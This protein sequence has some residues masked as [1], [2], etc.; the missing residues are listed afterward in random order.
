MREFLGSDYMQDRYRSGEVNQVLAE[1]TKAEKDNN[2]GDSGWK[3]FRRMFV[4]FG[5]MPISAM[6]WLSHA[7]CGT[8]LYYST[9]KK[10]AELYPEDEAKRL[11][12]MDTCSV[13][14]MTQQSAM[15]HNL[16]ETQRSGESLMKMFTQFRTANRQYMSYEIN[17]LGEFVSNP[18]W[19]RFKRAGKTVVLNHLVLPALFN[20]IGLFM[21]ALLGDDIDDDDWEYFWKSTALKCFL[22]V[23]TGWYISAFFGE[24]IKIAFLNQYGKSS[25]TMMSSTAFFRIVDTCVFAIRDL[26]KNG[27]D[28][29]DLWEHLDKL[30][31]ASFAPYRLVRKAYKN[32]TD[33]KEGSIW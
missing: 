23:F 16:G 5:F 21:D 12:I 13:G 6:D 4:K 14:E 18:S 1:I 11:A 19:A 8:M 27:L 3:R 22:D 2:V 32:A 15:I 9:Y 24:A 31:R 17:A 7:L 28:D 20:G 10:Y 30:G 26:T 33:N 29:F 25:D